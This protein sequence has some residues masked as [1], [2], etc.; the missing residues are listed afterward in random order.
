MC[1]SDTRNMSCKKYCSLSRRMCAMRYKWSVQWRSM[2]WKV[3]LAVGNVNNWDELMATLSMHMRLRR[4]HRTQNKGRHVR[5]Q[6]H[7]AHFQRSRYRSSSQKL[8]KVT[9]FMNHS[10]RSI[11]SA[12]RDDLAHILCALNEYH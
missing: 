10:C 8:E 12:G 7:G 5:V 11:T 6:N 3:A 4:P 2:R 1:N 9:D